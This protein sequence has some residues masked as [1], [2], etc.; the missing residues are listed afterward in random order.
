V[1]PYS[2]EQFTYELQE[3]YRKSIVEENE[4]CNCGVTLDRI[5]ILD[6]ASIV[7]P[8][9][10][11]R[12]LEDETA[13]CQCP[14]QEVIPCSQCANLQCA[15]EL[16]GHKRVNVTIAVKHDNLTTAGDQLNNQ[17]EGTV[18][19]DDFT[20]AQSCPPNTFK[21]NVSNDVCTPCQEYSS[22]PPGSTSRDNCTCYYDFHKDA[23]DGSC[24]RVCAA[25]FESRGGGECHGCLPSY[26]K[27]ERG[28]EDCTRCPP[29]SLSF[30][31]NQTSITSCLCEQG[32]IRNVE[33]KLCDPCPA[34]SFNNRVNDTEC[35]NC[36]TP[37]PV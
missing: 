2:F 5:F 35:F 25:G 27:P 16:V 31:Y 30:A 10:G 6:I 4:G 23:G 32:Y 7:S 33:S 8:A 37:C 13:M 3:D 34:G 11:R 19:E 14:G 28:D 22:S 18:V 26:Y 9:G 24:D 29:S 20:V 21:T 17:R 12:L 1:L 36:S 15:C